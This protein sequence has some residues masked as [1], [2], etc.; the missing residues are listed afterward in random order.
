MVS[1]NW[2]TTTERFR[3]ISGQLR[4][5]LSHQLSHT[6]PLSIHTS[7]SNPSG[8]Y[9]SRPCPSPSA[10]EIPSILRV[11]CSASFI[12]RQPLSSPRQV[13]AMCACANAPTAEVI[14]RVIT[15]P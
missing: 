1:L 7:F 13:N 10:F 8:H 5:L 2:E 9:S 14:P 4:Y 3:Y 15:P 11:Q 6:L 12:R